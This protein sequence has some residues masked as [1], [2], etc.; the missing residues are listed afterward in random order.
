MPVFISKN[1]NGKV[2]NVVFSKSRELAVA[3]WHGKGIYPYS[4]QVVSDKNMEDHP[5]GVLP[6]LSTEKKELQPKFGSSA[7]EYLVVV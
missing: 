4:I 2:E 6:I 1:Y 3:Y 7:Q 5:T